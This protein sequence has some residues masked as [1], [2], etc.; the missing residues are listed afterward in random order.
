MRGS[1]SVR[2]RGPGSMAGTVRRVI[3][4]SL[5]GATRRSNP[6]LLAH[7]LQFLD[8]RAPSSFDKLRMRSLAMTHNLS[9]TLPHLPGPDPGSLLFLTPAAI[10]MVSPHSEPVELRTMSIMR[11]PSSF[12]KLRM[13]EGK[14]RKLA[15]LRPSFRRTPESSLPFS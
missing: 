4:S 10:L 8:C 7:G 1:G 13:R 2:Q 5:R 6:E 14:I 9:I 15:V 3:L 12:D 11:L